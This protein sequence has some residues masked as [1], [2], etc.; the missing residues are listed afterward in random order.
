MKSIIIILVVLFSYISFAQEDSVA[1]EVIPVEN[2]YTF[3][4]TYYTPKGPVE[5]VRIAQ[6]KMK[7]YHNRGYYAKSFNESVH[8]RTLRNGKIAK[9]FHVTVLYEKTKTI[10]K[11]LPINNN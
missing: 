1:T 8:S 5:A 6:V 2:K 4:E 9:M 11:E 7:D 3:L 10:L